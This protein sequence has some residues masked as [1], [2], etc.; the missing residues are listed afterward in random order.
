MF[1][2]GQ[3]WF[4][5]KRKTLGKNESGQ[6]Y[7]GDDKGTCQGV[8]LEGMV[9]FLADEMSAFS[10]RYKILNELDEQ[11]L[12]AAVEKAKQQIIT[13]ND[14]ATK[15]FDL[16]WNKTKDQLRAKYK[17]ASDLEKALQEADKK[18]KQNRYPAIQKRIAELKKDH[19]ADKEN[20]LTRF[21]ALI[22]QNAAAQ[23]VEVYQQIDLYPDLLVREFDWYFM[24]QLPEDL[25][26][27]TNAYVF[28]KGSS[29]A[30]LKLYKINNATKTAEEFKIADTS[31]LQRMFKR[32]IDSQKPLQQQLSKPT[33]AALWQEMRAQCGFLRKSP[34]LNDPLTTLSL[35]MPKKLE[36]QGGIERA[37]LFAGIYTYQ[38]LV[39]YFTSLQDSISKTQ[40][41]LTEAIAI[42]LGSADHW[43][44]LGYR[45]P[46]PTWSLI[47]ANQLAL[48][49]KSYTTEEIAHK[50]M[51]AFGCKERVALTSNVFVSKTAA[52]NYQ[53]A[54]NAWKE[55]AKWQQL[56][57]LDKEINQQDERG[58]TWL[59]CAARD[60]LTETVRSLLAKGANP[61][62]ARTD[63]V[64][65][66]YIAAQNGHADIV[67]L[68]LANKANPNLAR[69]DDG[70]TPLNVAVQNGHTDI[71]ELLL[72]NK[73][74]PNLARTD[75]GATPLYMAA[76]IGHT[77]IVN[78]LLLAE[79]IIID[80]GISAI[81]KILIDFA[82]QK[83]RATEVTALL[84][85]HNNNRLPKTI[86]DFT[87]LHAAVFFGHLD[88]AKT[89]LEH[90]ADVTKKTGGMSVMEIANAMGKR[91]MIDLITLHNTI[92][93]FNYLK[94][95][96]SSLTLN[97]EDKATISE[98]IKKHELA[99]NQTANLENKNSVLKQ[100]K[101]DVKKFS[102]ALQDQY[103][104]RHPM[105]SVMGV[106]SLSREYQAI[107]QVLLHESKT[108]TP[109]SKAAKT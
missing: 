92:P 52:N 12:A 86:S 68:L 3:G 5:T 34:D 31:N 87:P 45:P 37:E 1:P 18:H 9:A 96:L 80:S 79:N 53:L 99:F 88:I 8:A 7:R 4:S 76:Q 25:S 16:E 20:E 32:K 42:T 78:H 63:G 17:V 74:N 98:I 28:T 106:F 22:E 35:M 29:S 44:T 90:G 64:T 108:E 61:N 69:T 103:Q 81:T 27:L 101:K 38:D 6:G 71:V 36:D 100:F 82:T 33:Q 55:T 19:F 65:P 46:N 49:Q 57:R 14:Q 102:E 40:P 85:S 11:S 73:A 77:A 70:A 48:L 47:D 72:A 91:G 56:H 93:E 24:E 23:T 54:L 39:D 95:Q 66:L 21:N 109:Q 30:P 59:Y 51:N 105:L 107:Q 97:D 13:W 58:G 84:K 62:L 15:E 67:E 43:I 75:N 83:N 104:Q 41:P 10:E 26:Q 2:R 60:N 94:R 89:L 50:V